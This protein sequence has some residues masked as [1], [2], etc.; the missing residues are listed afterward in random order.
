[1]KVFLPF[2]AIRFIKYIP[3]VVVFG[4]N[5]KGIS[6]R[7]FSQSLL[8]FLNFWPNK[9]KQKDWYDIVYC[10]ML[11]DTE[12]SLQYEKVGCYKDMHRSQR[13]LPFFLMNDRDV[14]HQHFSGKLVD[15]RNWDVYVPDLACRC[16]KKAKAK[17]W[18]F[19]GLQ[20]YGKNFH[21]CRSV[22]L[23]VLIR[24]FMV[25]NLLPK[26]AGSLLPVDMGRS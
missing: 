19:F 14:Y 11:V 20:F 3:L 4:A 26:S 12:C 24:R 5:E 7:S 1:M 22:V 17:G 2:W 15:W 16:A 6:F 23:H 13:P 25:A 21:C 9:N 10:V 8:E 18:T